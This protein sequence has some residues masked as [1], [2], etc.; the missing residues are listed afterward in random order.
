MLTTAEI[1]QCSLD[2]ALIGK[3]IKKTRKKSVKR[4]NT[5]WVFAIAHQPISVIL[6]MGKSGFLWSCCSRSVLYLRKVWITS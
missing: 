5:W 4:R 6:K 2:T 1:A 3:R